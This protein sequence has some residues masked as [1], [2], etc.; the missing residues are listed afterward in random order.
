M[1]P[2]C[3]A[4][5]EQD[6]GTSPG[7]VQEQMLSQSKDELAVLPH[8]GAKQCPRDDHSRLQW[9]GWFSDG[10]RFPNPAEL[11][12]DSCFSICVRAVGDKTLC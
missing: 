9:P 5:V 3:G 12:E 10:Q 8:G 6:S 4:D 1:T 7:A 2:W 11:L